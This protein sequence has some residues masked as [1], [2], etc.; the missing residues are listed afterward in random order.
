VR[1]RVDNVTHITD[2]E[3]LVNID[4]LWGFDD[5]VIGQRQIY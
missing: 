5:H 3:I 4:A 1:Q 2:D